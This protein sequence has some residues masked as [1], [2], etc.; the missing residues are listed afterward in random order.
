[1]K[2][3]QPRWFTTA[4]LMF[5]SAAIAVGAIAGPAVASAEPVNPNPKLTEKQIKNDCEVQD[6]D[7]GGSYSTSVDKNGNRQSTCSYFD[8]DGNLWIDHYT[9][10]TFGGTTGP[11]RPKQPTP[12]SAVVILPPGATNIQ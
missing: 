4:A 6:K 12:P 3:T 1:M 10:G 7:A 9:N 8:T 11:F 5:A 2:N